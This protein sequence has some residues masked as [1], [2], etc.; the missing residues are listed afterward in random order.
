MCS[1]EAKD[2]HLPDRAWIAP[3]PFPIAS[4]KRDRTAPESRDPFRWIAR[5]NRPGSR[6]QGAASL[7]SSCSSCR[8]LRRKLSG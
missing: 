4:C 1:Q 8:L 2:V 3:P 7:G 5:S 6:S